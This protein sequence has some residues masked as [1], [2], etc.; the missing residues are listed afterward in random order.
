MQA[1]GL[2]HLGPLA[3][4]R[5]RRR[6]LGDAAVAEDEVVDAVDAGDRVEHGGTAQEQVRRLAGA[7]VEDVG[8]KLRRLAAHAGW[9]IGV[10]LPW[11]LPAP[12][13]AGRSLPASSS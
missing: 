4:R 11:S 3:L 13:G 12:T 7:D 9:P 8:Q 2:E 6:Q 1:L 5:A 10:G